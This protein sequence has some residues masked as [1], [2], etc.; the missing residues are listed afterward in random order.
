ML[1]WKRMSWPLLLSRQ[2]LKSHFKA[3]EPFRGQAIVFSGRNQRV[4]KKN[5]RTAL[6]TWPSWI[7]TGKDLLRQL[8]NWKIS[9]TCFGLSKDNFFLA[10]RR[11][12]QLRGL[13]KKL[14]LRHNIPADSVGT[15]KQVF[16]IIKHRTLGNWAVTSV[17]ERCTL[18]RTLTNLKIILD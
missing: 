7:K 10:S 16:D 1:A 8:Y 12:F 4:K 15:L 9:V 6:Y 14:G 13:L 17:G 18:Q 11:N 2:V 3:S 5:C